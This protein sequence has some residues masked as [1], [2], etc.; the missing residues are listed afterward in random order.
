M[1]AITVTTGHAPIPFSGFGGYADAGQTDTPTVDRSAIVAKALDRYRAAALEAQMMCDTR[2]GNPFQQIFEWATN[3]TFTGSICDRAA[4]MKQNVD[5]YAAHLADPS[6]TDEQ[7]QEILG[8]MNKETNISDLI[9]LYNASSA[10]GI[11]EK[12]IDPRNVI[13]TAAGLIPWWVW[14]LGI[15]AVAF[16]VFGG[17]RRG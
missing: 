12:S 14:A 13:P 16:V 1:A 2:S 11:I 15:G 17:R 6:T 8:F 3:S 9:T 7:V 10:G 5:S 4:V